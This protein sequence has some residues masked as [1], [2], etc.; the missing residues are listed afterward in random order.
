MLA[1]SFFSMYSIHSCF[2]ASL[3]VLTADSVVS[4]YK[5]IQK[6][7][8]VIHNAAMLPVFFRRGMFTF[9][10]HDGAMPASREKKKKKGVGGEK[11]KRNMP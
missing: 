7:S 10:L 4:P 8:I 5:E 6:K 11:R 2:S 3:V 9:A 1:P